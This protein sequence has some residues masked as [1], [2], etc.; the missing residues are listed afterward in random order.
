MLTHGFEAKEGVLKHP[1]LKEQ[2]KNAFNYL[3]RK[4]YFI[5]LIMAIM[6]RCQTGCK[7]AIALRLFH[8]FNQEKINN[9]L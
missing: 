9:K 6:L 5:N 1:K 7:G 2:E 4:V 8:A 3:L